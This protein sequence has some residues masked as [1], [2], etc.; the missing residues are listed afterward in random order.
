MSIDSKSSVDRWVKCISTSG[1]I[2]AVALTAKE[3]IQK[4]I[5]RHE[6]SEIGAR[7]LAEGAIAGLI[8]ASYSKGEE[9]INLNIKGSGWARHAIFDVN[10][11]AEV[12]G[13][14][15]ERPQNE[16]ELARHVGPWGIGLLSV[17]RTKHDDSQPYIGTVPLVT[18]RL[19]KDLTFYWLQS[20]Q[21]QSAVGIDVVMDGTTVVHAEG[22]LIQALPGAS[23]AD[24]AYI[25]RHLKQFPTLDIDAVQKSSPVNLLSFLLNDQSF[26]LL[27]EKNIAFKCPCSLERVMRSLVLLGPAD[28]KSMVD[29]KKDVEIICDFCNEKYLISPDTIVGILPH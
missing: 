16:V 23:D 12:R 6:A 28:L 26:N 7:A 22:F 10:A 14:V 21:V 5:D 9:K 17:I 1:T 2:R 25:E 11:E 15:I 13:Y 8:L 18:G 24:I 29:E 4:I 20:E 27:E 19:A 3:T